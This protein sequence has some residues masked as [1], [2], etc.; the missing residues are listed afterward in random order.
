MLHSIISILE[1][2]NF[3][4][5]FTYLSIWTKAIKT[6]GNGKSTIMKPNMDAHITDVIFCGNHFY[7]WSKWLRRK[8]RWNNEGFDKDWVVTFDAKSDHDA[9]MMGAA[10]HWDKKGKKHPTFSNYFSVIWIFSCFEICLFLLEIWLFTLAIWLL[11][12]EIYPFL[13]KV[14]LVLLWNVGIL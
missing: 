3:Y 1:I 14:R 13:L 8:R 9:Q 11:L 6:K 4:G 12:L 2:W 10:A 7:F 5:N